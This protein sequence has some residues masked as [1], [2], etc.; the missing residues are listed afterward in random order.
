[1]KLLHVMSD[2]LDRLFDFLGSDT[3]FYI[4]TIWFVIIFISML[5][6]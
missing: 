5:I 6:R 3:M 2:V 4:I 1:M